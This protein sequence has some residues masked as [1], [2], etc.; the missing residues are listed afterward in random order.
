MHATLNDGMFDAEQ[1]GN[2]RFHV[3]SMFV[4]CDD[5]TGIVDARAQRCRVER[6]QTKKGTPFGRPFVQYL[7]DLM[8]S[9]AMRPM[10]M[11]MAVPNPAPMAMNPHPMAMSVAM[12]P[13]RMRMM[14]AAGVSLRV[15]DRERYAERER[16][17]G[18]DGGCEY[19][20]HVCFLPLLGWLATKGPH[21]LVTH[22]Q[23][24]SV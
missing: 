20:L 5:D 2:A 21:K 17:D 22:S 13:T 18:D 24:G 4:E 1:F 10:A 8:V 14:M 12:A 3:R 23:A 11:V 6:V 15:R 7:A 9:A 19:A 16:A